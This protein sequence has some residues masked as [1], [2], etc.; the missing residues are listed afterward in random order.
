VTGLV[1]VEHVRLALRDRVR[2]LPAGGET[3]MRTRR[4]RAVLEEAGV[5]CDDRAD[6]HDVDAVVLASERGVD[7]MIAS[8]LDDEQ[9]EMA[10]ARIIAR[11]LAGGLKSPIDFKAEYADSNDVPHP[12][13]REEERMVVAL[14][15]AITSGQLDTAPR[16]LFE[17]VPAFTLAFTPR[18]AA[19]STLG[20]FHWWSGYWY[21]RSN[22]YRAWRARPG[23]SNAI[24]RVCG[25]LNRASAPAA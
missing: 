25:I 13:E 10:Y 21:K 23:V 5:T 6:L 11:L 20:G 18:T 16:P 7:A 3:R 9:R 8:R 4:L 17:D 2:T 12:R 24:E 1:I 19:R 14:A 15:R 22:M